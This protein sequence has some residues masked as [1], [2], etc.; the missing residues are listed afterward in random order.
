MF[1]LF[2]VPAHI[3]IHAYI[4]VI[5]IQCF[6]CSSDSILN[7]SR[8]E[9][10]KSKKNIQ[11]YLLTFVPMTNNVEPALPVMTFHGAIFFQIP[12]WTR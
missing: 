11:F 4:F 5:Y 6:Y 12:S 3:H 7:Q 10:V 2:R 8:V 9:L 1:I